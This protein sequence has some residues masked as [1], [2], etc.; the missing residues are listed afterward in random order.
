MTWAVLEALGIVLSVGLGA[1]VGWSMC[2]R[3]HRR[4][5]VLDFGQALDQPR[6]QQVIST[7]EV[8]PRMDVEPPPPP[9][10]GG[11]AWTANSSAYVVEY[12]APSSAR[13]TWWELLE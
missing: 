2:E 9:P 4:Q 3:K 10:S 5:S 12:L 11:S 6:V 1:A 7:A 8:P 13:I